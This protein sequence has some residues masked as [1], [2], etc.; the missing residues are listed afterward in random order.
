MLLSNNPS[1]LFHVRLRQIRVMKDLEVCEV[2]DLAFI[3]GAEAIFFHTPLQMLGSLLSWDV[4]G[5]FV[6]PLIYISSHQQGQQGL[7]KKKKELL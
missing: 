2:Y 4:K 1:A 6:P 7:T 3:L 5:I